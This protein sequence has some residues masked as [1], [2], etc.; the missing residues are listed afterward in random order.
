VT[1]TGSGAKVE[2]GGGLPGNDGGTSFSSP[3]RPGTHGFFLC[4]ELYYRRS[5]RK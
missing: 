1:E 5:R 3:G 4:F 2:N